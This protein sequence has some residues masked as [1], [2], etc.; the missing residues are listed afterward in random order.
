[1]TG[2]LG[3]S[4]IFPRK[5]TV[6]G[7]KS[8]DVSRRSLRLVGRWLTVGGNS[9]SRTGFPVRRRSSVS[10]SLTG[11]RASK[12]RCAARRSPP[13][14]VWCDSTLFLCSGIVRSTSSAINLGD[15]A[16]TVG[17]VTGGLAGAIWGVQ[18]IPCRWTTYLNGS[19]NTPE[20]VKRYDN[21]ALQVLARCLLGLP[22]VMTTE[23]EL[24]AGPTE[25]S[26]RL[27]AADLL[28]ATSASDD[29]AVVSLCRTDG[30]FVGHPVRREVFLIDREGDAN[31]A[32]RDAVTD[33]VESIEAFLQEGR[34]VLVHCHGGRSR[35]GLI[36]RAWAM[37]AN[38]LTAAESDAWLKERWT[39]YAPY[40]DTFCSH[41]AQEHDLLR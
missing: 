7:D 34:T 28:G 21:A 16:D 2:V 38:G 24:P 36:L 41:L 14:S 11:C 32:L 17:C 23:P 35:T 13:T 37:S 31:G 40:N 15:D 19:V 27:W 30:R 20:G 5:R 39:R 3:M 29:W 26:D 6:S 22:T 4:S 10:L 9:I 25:I 1:M 18:R 33:A 8:A 12:V